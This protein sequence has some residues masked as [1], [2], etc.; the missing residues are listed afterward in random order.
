[1]RIKIPKAP[2]PS[3][4]EWVSNLCDWVLLAVMSMMVLVAVTM[5]AVFFLMVIVAL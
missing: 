4:I 1:M 5:F 2:D 3:E